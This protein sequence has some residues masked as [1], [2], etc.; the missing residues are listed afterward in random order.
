MPEYV[1][2][3]SGKPIEGK[4]DFSFA[5]GKIVFKERPSIALESSTD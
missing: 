3:K 2:Y 5:G 4:K 1:D